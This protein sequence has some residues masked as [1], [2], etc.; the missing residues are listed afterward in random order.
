MNS[1]SK[2]DYDFMIEMCEM[3]SFV[4]AT[5]VKTYNDFKKRELEMPW[6]TSSDNETGMCDPIWL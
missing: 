1:F 5:N 2:T 6:S 3:S 4:T